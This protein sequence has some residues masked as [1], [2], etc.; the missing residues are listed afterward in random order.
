METCNEE[1]MAAIAPCG[2]SCETCFAH[3]DGDIRK[4]AMKLK[5]K[6]GNFEGY[7]K[8]FETMMDE[9]VFR[10]YADF[11][12]ILVYFAS[13]HCRGCRKE[14][15]RMFN[16]CGIRKCHQEK[17]IDFCYQCNNFPCNRTN[18]DERLYQV[19]VILNEKIRKSGIESYYEK[20]RVRPRY[21]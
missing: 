20:A 2:L 12:E 4:Y 6:L 15:C 10:K 5:E 11:K 17:Q 21:V 8:R 13:E 9:P 19:W 7:A 1:I 14:Q 3:V 16:N 18:F